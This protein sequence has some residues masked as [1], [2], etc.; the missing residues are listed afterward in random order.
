[1]CLPHVLFSHGLSFVILFLFMRKWFAVFTPFVLVGKGILSISHL[2]EYKYHL[3]LLL[4]M[5][6]LLEDKWGW[7]KDICSD[8]LP[9]G[10]FYAIY[11]HHTVHT[12]L[13]LLLSSCTVQN[14]G[15]LA[16]SVNFTENHCT[17][18][19]ASLREMLQ[20]HGLSCSYHLLSLETYR[21]ENVRFLHLTA[22]GIIVASVCTCTIL[23]VSWCDVASL[24]IQQLHFQCIQLLQHWLDCRNRSALNK[25]WHAIFLSSGSTQCP[26]LQYRDE[27]TRLVSQH[28][29]KTYSISYRVFLS[30][31][32]YK[33]VLCQMS[34]PLVNQHLMLFIW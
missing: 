11:V 10:P 24:L 2:T 5:R 17:N 25:L 15:K 19:N 18:S 21:I 20:E 1:M 6:I 32:M 28:V 8:P 33:A 13:L 4:E 23:Q 26:S 14:I 22:V 31:E 29:L 7:R 30:V 9:C 27:V 34:R 16:V 12:G 3:K